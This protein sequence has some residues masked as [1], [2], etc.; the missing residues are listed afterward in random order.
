MQK[1]EDE[2]PLQENPPFL[3]NMQTINMQGAISFARITE[4]E[5]PCLQARM[6]GSGMAAFSRRGRA[7]LA[8]SQIGSR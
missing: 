1:G 7:P 3:R 6:M 2:I 4:K 8:P 5:I